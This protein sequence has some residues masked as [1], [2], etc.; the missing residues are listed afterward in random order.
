MVNGFNMVGNKVPD[1]GLASAIN[2]TPP[3]G[4]SVQKWNVGITDF[5]VYTRTPFG[6]TW[7]PSVPS[8]DVAEGFFLNANGAYNWVRNFTVQ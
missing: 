2:L 6:T 3:T 7:S 4:S 8:I 1:A 5:D